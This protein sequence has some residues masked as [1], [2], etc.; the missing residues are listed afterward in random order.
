MKYLSPISIKRQRGQIPIAEILM[1]TAI[2]VPLVLTMVFLR[3]EVVSLL[4]YSF[5][6]IVT[7]SGL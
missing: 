3:T 1:I 6:L 5:A 7:R 2:A 4:T